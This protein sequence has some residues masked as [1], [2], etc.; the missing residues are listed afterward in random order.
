M[1]TIGFWN[2]AKRRQ[3]LPHLACL[4]QAHAVDVL[5][6]AECPKNLKPAISALNNLGIGVYREEVNAK[7]KVRAIT[8]LPAAEFVHYATGMARELAVWRVHAPK[9]TPKE[10]LLAG[11]HLLSKAGGSE[12]NDQF[13]VA[14]EVVEELVEFEEGRPSPH[15]NTVLVG[16]FNM[17]PYD[18]GMTSV[19]GIHGQMTKVLAEQPDRVHRHQPRRRFYNPMWGLFGDRTPGPP[20]THY[21]RSSVLHNPYWG[22]LDQVLIRPPLIGRFNQL[23]ILDNDGNH[24]LCG[25]DGAPDKRHL[26]DH[27]PV[28]FRLD[29]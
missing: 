10:L 25:P 20:G 15:R 7:A 16:D 8:R 29:V 14:K 5:M 28:L 21:W 3:T 4:A 1:I 9:L 13:S 12:A 2:L 6:L 11:V 24:D 17:H 19:T 27:L 23:T 26:S 22:M 18:P